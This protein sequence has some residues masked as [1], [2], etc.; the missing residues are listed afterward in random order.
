MPFRWLAEKQRQT[1]FWKQTNTEEIFIYKWN[2]YH[3]SSSQCPEIIVRGCEWVP[4][5]RILCIHDGSSTCEHMVDVTACKNSSQTMSHHGERRWA[6]NPMPNF[7]VG[8]G[9]ANFSKWHTHPRILGQHNWSW[10]GFVVCWL[11]ILFLC[12]CW[13]KT[14]SWI[15]EDKEEFGGWIWSK[16]TAWNSQKN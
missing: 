4:R 3:S 1:L 9:E 7:G 15:D 10:L 5:G 8:K 16:Y 12:C 11:I 2:I 13:F 14:Q 6:H